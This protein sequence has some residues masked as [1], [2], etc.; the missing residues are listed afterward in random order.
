VKHSGE[1]TAARSGRS[2]HEA[3]PASSDTNAPDDDRRAC[4]AIRV[5][6]LHKPRRPSRASL[7]L[8]ASFCNPSLLVPSKAWRDPSRSA[9]VRSVTLLR[10]HLD[11]PLM[12]PTHQPIAPLGGR[13][14]AHVDA[15]LGDDALAVA[16]LDAG[17]RAQQ[18]NGLLERG[19]LLPDRLG[20]VEDLLIEEVQVAEDRAD[21]DGVQMVEAALQCFFEL[22]DLLAQPALASSARISGSRVPR[23]A[24]Q[25]SPVQTCRGCRSRRSQ[26]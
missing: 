15:D 25:A 24:R 12:V 16:A 13:E 19:D 9:K 20:E 22:K 5:R 18:L 17:D 8:H 11:A 26:D 3:Q 14:H 21:P 1:T 2:P 4:P 6:G 10:N 7:H 23:R